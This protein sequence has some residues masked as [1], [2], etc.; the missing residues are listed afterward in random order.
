MSSNV[1]LNND[2]HGAYE[3]LLLLQFLDN[4]T[5]NTVLKGICLTFSLQ[6]YSEQFINLCTVIY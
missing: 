2:S 3:F 1:R 4:Y 5:N 6:Q